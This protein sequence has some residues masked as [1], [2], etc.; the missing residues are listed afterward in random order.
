MA[1]N[2]TPFTARVQADS[3]GSWEA[4]VPFAEIS[5]GLHTI[6]VVGEDGSMDESLLFVDRP[7]SVVEQRSIFGGGV[8]VSS[9]AAPLVPPAFAVA[10]FAFLTIIVLLAANGVRLGREADR[11]ERSLPARDR[12]RHRHG[13][14][15]MAACLAAVGLS[16]FAGILVNQ[17]AG[18]LRSLI[19]QEAPKP[20]VRASVA[21]AVVTPFEHAPVSGADL[22]AGSLSVRTVE[23]GRF[24]FSD[25]DAGEGIRLTHPALARALRLK[26]PGVDDAGTARVNA[27]P[28]AFL[29][30]AQMY[31]AL[32]YALDADARASRRGLVPADASEQ[33]AVIAS[34]SEDVRSGTVTVT[35]RVR[36]TDIPY[37]IR[38]EGD[39]WAVTP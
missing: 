1:D 3:Q 35:A 21:G 34:V 2:A 6:T 28:I 23:S 36:G 18:T 32:V 8:W 14:N 33:E 39:G 20:P 7:E 27:F 16:F 15:A 9:G 37:V 22:T 29:F 13:R 12:K 24:A 30:D 10:M 19:P 11:A 5:E 25:I 4:S 38:K 26:L 17:S 31:N